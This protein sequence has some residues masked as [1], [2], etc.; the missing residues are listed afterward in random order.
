MLASSSNLISGT[1]GVPDD[2]KVKMCEGPEQTTSI[3]ENVMSEEQE[4]EYGLN[5]KKQITPRALFMG[6]VIGSLMTIIVLKLSL[7]TGIIPSLNIAS[8]LLGFIGLGAYVRSASKCCGQVLEMTPQ[9]VT[10][11]QTFATSYGIM[12]FYLGLSSYILGMDENSARLVAG[13]NATLDYSQIINPSL[14]NVI[15]YGFAVSFGGIFVLI[16]L[17][18]SLVIDMKLQYPSG[19]ATASMIVGF[20]AKD[21]TAKRQFKAFMTWFLVSFFFDLF[22]WFFAGGDDCGFDV[23][24]TFGLRA[25]EKYNLNFDFALN[26]IGVGILCSHLVNYSTLL[27]ALIAWVGLWPFIES[28]EGVWYPEGA[29]TSMNGLLGYQVFFALTVILTDGF[30]QM[31]KMA[32]KVVVDYR[33]RRKEAKTTEMEQDEEDVFEARQTRIRD[34]IFKS[35]PLSYL[36][37]ALLYII[38]IGIGLAVI[39]TIYKVEWYLVL[40]AYLVMP[41]FAIPNSYI[42]GLTDWD[43]SSMFAKLFIFVYAGISSVGVIAGLAACGI[44]LVGTG[45]AATLMQDMKTGYLTKSSPMA[46]MLTQV[47]GT[48]TG[49]I[50]GPVLFFVLFWGPFAVGDPHGPYPAPYATIYRSM[51]VLGT[52]G[53]GALP[54]H[55]L[56]ICGYFFAATL[57]ILVSRDLTEHYMP[58]GR[59][60]SILL[61]IIPIPSAMAIPFYIPPAFAVDMA[62]GSLVKY[63]WVSPDLIAM[64]SGLIAGDGLFTIPQ[65][66]FA[67]ASLESP[68]CMGFTK[69]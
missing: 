25:L 65:A 66:I 63:F 30:Y 48:F 10:V 57:V 58:K 15:P 26:Y 55:C 37:S 50:M 32:Y 35:E 33:A 69:A 62:I 49:V 38:C 40:I 29:T 64:A 20:F 21:S 54:D 43:M 12:S 44:S 27:G 19:T 6:F 22:K 59:V 5:W 52:E 28:K 17:R 18:Q 16:K 41:L 46:M 4:I 9:E 24:P 45:Q 14:Q 23:F 51:A 13:P 61:C 11:V 68:I 47:I 31:G 2:A 7:T 1:F 3:E 34:S 67:F 56:E 42:T 36:G 8:G 39:P 53:F 60:R